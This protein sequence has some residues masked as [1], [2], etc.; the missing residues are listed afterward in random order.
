[1]KIV[2]LKK[3]KSADFHFTLA[4]VSLTYLTTSIQISRSYRLRQHK[5]LIN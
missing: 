2:L 5:Q 1:M 3:N 4:E